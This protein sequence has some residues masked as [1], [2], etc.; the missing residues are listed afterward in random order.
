[1]E[2]KIITNHTELILHIAELKMNKDIQGYELQHSFKEIVSSLNMVSLFKESSTQDH[3]LKV[4]K[5]FVNMA[6][7]L[8]IDLI[9]GKHLSIKGYLSAIM[10]ERFTSMMVDNNLLNIISGISSMFN[11]KSQNEKSEE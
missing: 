6:L 3:P 5:S 4:A 10:V 1:M 2:N 9:L 8:I 7:D 11:R